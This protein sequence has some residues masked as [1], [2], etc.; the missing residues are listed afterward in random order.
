MEMNTSVNIC[1]AGAS[2]A[3]AVIGLILSLG[4]HYT[5]NEYKKYLVAIFSMLTAY[6]VSNLVLWN[7]PEEKGFGY[8]IASYICLFGESLFSSIIL[9]VLNNFL[10]YCAGKKRKNRHGK[11]GVSVVP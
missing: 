11:T 10:L 6:T 1:L 9:P 8:M 4:A 3:I 2:T 5:Q 7:I